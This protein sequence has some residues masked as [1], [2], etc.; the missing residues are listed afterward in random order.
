MYRRR[1][2]CSGRCPAVTGSSRKWQWVSGGV[3]G[4]RDNLNPLSDRGRPNRKWLL[5]SDPSQL[6]KVAESVLLG[7][8]G[9]SVK[10]KACAGR[11]SLEPQS[12]KWVVA[13]AGR[14]LLLAAACARRHQVPDVRLRLL[15][16]LRRRPKPC[17]QAAAAAHLRAGCHRRC[18]SVAWRAQL[19]LDSIW[20]SLWLRAVWHGARL[21]AGELGKALL[22]RELAA[23]GLGS[24]VGRALGSSTI[25]RPLQGNGQG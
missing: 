17:R 25:W 19:R 4:G 14:Q 15:L 22:L 3:F 8:S 7:T 2:K 16:R 21:L 11:Y 23:R 24:T 20:H 12:R 13:I 9:I 18:G 5:T 1:A 6:H 10:Q